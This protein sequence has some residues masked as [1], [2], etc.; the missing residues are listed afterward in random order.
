MDNKIVNT[1]ICEF[2]YFKIF[3]NLFSNRKLTN[4][5]NFLL[6]LEQETSLKQKTGNSEIKYFPIID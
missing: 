4:D 5:V 2:C 1:A 6:Q 3:Y